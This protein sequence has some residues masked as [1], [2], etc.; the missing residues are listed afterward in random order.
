MI[1]WLYNTDTGKKL[2]GRQTATLHTTNY[3]DT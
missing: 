3:E 2:Q 1:G